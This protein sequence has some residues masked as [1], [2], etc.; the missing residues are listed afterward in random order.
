M[1]L[2]IKLLGYQQL[3]SGEDLLNAECS[4]VDV[5]NDYVLGEESGMGPKN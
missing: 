3:S 5:D 2:R 1:T 4:D